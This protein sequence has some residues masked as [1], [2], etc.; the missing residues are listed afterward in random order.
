MPLRSAAPSPEDRVALPLAASG[1]SRQ[2]RIS[3]VLQVVDTALYISDPICQE[4][5]DGEVSQG[6]HILRT[7][8]GLNGG[9]ILTE[10]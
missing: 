3:A 8:L 10:D 2:E 9:A 7:M 6:G 1:S 5:S 4:V